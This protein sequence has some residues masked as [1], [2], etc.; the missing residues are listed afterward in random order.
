MLHAS[1]GALQGCSTLDICKVQEAIESAESGT[2][3]VLTEGTVAVGLEDV[4]A[5]ATQAREH[6]GIA[7]YA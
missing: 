4:E 3:A 6:T 5:E 2:V 7:A 1:Q